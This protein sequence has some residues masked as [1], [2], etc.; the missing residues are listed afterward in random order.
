MFENR[1]REI[2]RYFSYARGKLL[3]IDI[4]KEKDTT[5]ICTFLNI[6]QDLITD[7]PHENKT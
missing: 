7:M 1:N 4:T 2:K 5:K 6:P 3:V